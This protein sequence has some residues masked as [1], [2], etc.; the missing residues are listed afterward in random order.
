MADRKLLR[1][2]ATLLFVGELLSLLA[3]ALHPSRE[4][5]NNHTAV[6]AEYANSA[7]WT[8]V[9]LGQF[10][11][12]AVI[13]AGLLV[14]FFALNVL[15][16]TPGWMGR[17]AAVS[18]VV[19]LALY[20]VL[21]AVDGVALKQAVDAWASAPAAEKAARF[22]SAEAIRWLEWGTRSYHSFMFGLSLVLF[23]TVIVWTARVPRPIGYL[24]GLSGLAYLVQGFVLGSEGFSV[25]NTVPQLL[26]Y[27]LVLAWSI[28]LLILAWRMKES[29]E[30]ATA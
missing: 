22:A 28:W 5:P 21:Q 8:A 6:F 24:M 3:G 13:I 27:L 30:A 20:G 15:H 4:N 16:G 7:D 14:L 2:S 9:H 11:G 29:V 18:A 1:L 25:T 17:F 19:A 26:G 12:I 23:A 10:A